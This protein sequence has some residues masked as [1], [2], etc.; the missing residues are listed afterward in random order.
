M[1]NITT[2]RYSAEYNGSIPAPTPP[3]PTPPGPTPPGP[4]PPGPNPPGPAPPGESSSSTIY[5]I[6][7]CSVA[8]LVALGIVIYCIK[9]RNKR[10]NQEID[11]Y[12]NLSP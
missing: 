2:F 4:A 6:V 7:G 1:P 11:Q 3:E 9:S 5:I 12:E 8:A 10:L